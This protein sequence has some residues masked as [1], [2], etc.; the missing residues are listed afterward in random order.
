[1]PDILVL[2]YSRN[3]SVKQ[4]AQFVGRG[5]E[6][7]PGMVTQCCMPDLATALHNIDTGEEQEL[8]P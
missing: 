3:G 4:M 6:T 7:V 2:Y 8:P 1:M 5:V